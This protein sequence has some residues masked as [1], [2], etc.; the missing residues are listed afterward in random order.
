MKSN[1]W[2]LLAVALTVTI[3]FSG[4]AACAPAP[5][6]EVI[7]ETVVV[8]EVVEKEVE[9]IVTEVVEVEKIVTEVVEKEVIVEVTAQMPHKGKIGF[10]HR[11]KSRIDPSAAQR[12]GGHDD[13]RRR[14]TLI[15]HPPQDVIRQFRHSALAALPNRYP[16]D[17]RIRHRLSRFDQKRRIAPIEPAGQRRG[18]DVE[19]TFLAGPLHYRPLGPGPQYIPLPLQAVQH[20][21]AFFT[22]SYHFP[23]PPVDAGSQVVFSSA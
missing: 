5:E 19:D 1:L 4:L 6:P 16:P 12:L 23:P 11:S 15:D 13:H 8:T 14:R 9:K 3:V 22:R 10:E 18:L 20:R 21:P 2:K 7:K 17:L